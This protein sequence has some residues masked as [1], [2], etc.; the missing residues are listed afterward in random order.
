MPRRPSLARM[1]AVSGNQ[2]GGARRGPC[3]KR[4]WMMKMVTRDRRRLAGI[5]GNVTS[6]AALAVMLVSVP[7]FARPLPQQDQSAVPDSTRSADPAAPDQL[8]KPTT[9]TDG[10]ADAPQAE[11]PASDIVVTGTRIT[12]NG[13]NA[14]TPT[15]VIGEQQIQQNAQA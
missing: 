2:T 4:G 9:T 11:A 7:A 10:T 14:P 5:S 3:G 15:T 1:I 13:F 6:V 12:A 8:T